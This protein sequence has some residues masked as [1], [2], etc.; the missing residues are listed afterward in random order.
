MNPSRVIV[1][2]CTHPKGGMSLG[3]RLPTLEHE[4]PE[5]SV[6]EVVDVRI[7]LPPG[8]VISDILFG[9]V[10]HDTSIE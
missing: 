7:G 3:C 1:K 5:C 6:I 10:G 9:R 8:E 2:H 4:G